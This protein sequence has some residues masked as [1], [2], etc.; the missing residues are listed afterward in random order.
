MKIAIEVLRRDGAITLTQLR[1][2]AFDQGST[3]QTVVA[4]LELLGCRTFRVHGKA[5]IA[6]PTTLERAL[7][8]ALEEA[9]QAE[10][11]KVWTCTI[12]V[13][14]KGRR[15]LYLTSLIQLQQGFLHAW[16]V[17]SN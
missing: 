7:A 15:L 9:R 14:C 13:S 5:Y 16:L 11:L 6:W 2:A 8:H 4:E 1:E 10:L 12:A 3:A 17:W